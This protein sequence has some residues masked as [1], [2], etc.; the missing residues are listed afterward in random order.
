MWEASW[1]IVDGVDG[2]LSMPGLIKSV[3]VKRSLANSKLTGC[4]Q[5][6]WVRSS[7]GVESQSSSQGKFKLSTVCR[8]AAATMGSLFSE[9][10]SLRQACRTVV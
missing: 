2:R 6:S 8:Q 5:V 9:F 10:S 3:S 4:S 7:R 1:S